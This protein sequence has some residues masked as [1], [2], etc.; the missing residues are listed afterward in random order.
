MKS[1][2]IVLFF[3]VGHMVGM[4]QEQKKSFVSLP[5]TVCESDYSDNGQVGL[6]GQLA[7]CVGEL[8][9]CFVDQAVFDHGTNKQVDSLF[10]SK[11]L[12]VKN[13][14][15][16]D[17]RTA[18]KIHEAQREK[19]LTKELLDTI[20]QGGTFKKVSLYSCLT[21]D[22][23]KLRAENAS[24]LLQNQT[25]Y[26][27][28]LPFLLGE[29]DARVL[30]RL[31][32]ADGDLR[33]CIASA[34]LPYGYLLLCSAI[35]AD[36]SDK[37]KV[38]LAAGAN[39]LATDSMAMS[40]E[41]PYHHASE[42]ARPAILGLFLNL[43]SGDQAKINAKTVAVPV[44]KTALDYAHTQLADDFAD[45][46]AARDVVRMLRQAGCRT[47]SELIAERVHFEKMGAWSTEIEGACCVPLDRIMPAEKQEERR[48]ASSSRVQF[49]PTVIQEQGE[50]MEPEN[51][52]KCFLTRGSPEPMPDWFDLDLQDIAQKSDPLSEC[53]VDR[54]STTPISSS[55]SSEDKQRKTMWERFCCSSCM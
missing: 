5:G 24:M 31:L 52:Q 54:L 10:L 2:M 38:L 53:T 34:D 41:T 35:D 37:V 29:C 19:E 33:F 48:S 47:A 26:L 9:Q 21:L 1:R 45:Q 49:A 40:I 50:A 6:D 20:A 13:Y 42:R 18:G 28:R 12:M 46:G 16:S 36:D 44:E 25:F 15:S 55:S 14:F 51:V 43:F 30:R 4:Q 32:V 3:F 23:K 7:D 22:R 8:I 39:P 11:E 27:K 17:M